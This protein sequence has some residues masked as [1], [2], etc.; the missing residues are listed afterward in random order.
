MK[1]KEILC[2]LDVEKAYDHLNRDFLTQV[3]E[4]MGFGGK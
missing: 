2:K 3:M 1:D 4:K